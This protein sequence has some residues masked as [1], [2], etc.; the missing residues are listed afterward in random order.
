MSTVILTSTH[1]GSDHCVVTKTFPHTT[2][3]DIKHKKIFV[4]CSKQFIYATVGDFDPKKIGGKV[5]RS[6]MRLLIEIAMDAKQNIINVN[7]EDL[8]T[9]F[10][11]Y[12]DR[13]GHTLLITQTT[14]HLVYYSKLNSCLKIAEVDQVIGIGAGGNYAE[15][16]ILGDIPIEDIWK[17]IAVHEPVSSEAHTIINLDILKPFVIKTKEKEKS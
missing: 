8:I 13:G 4:D 7:D 15:G 9:L 5:A 2:Y 1:I 12:L 6:F 11:A 17:I 10:D 16:L 3:V 14:R